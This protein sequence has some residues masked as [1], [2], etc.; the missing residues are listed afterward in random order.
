MK[1]TENP[2]AVKSF[3]FALKIVDLYDIIVKK[4][5]FSLGDQVLRSGTSIGANIREGL[6]GQSK[7]DFISKLNVA[8]KEAGETEYWLDLFFHS[9]IISQDD[10]DNLIKDC[11]ELI[12]ILI[13][14]IKTSR[15]NLNSQS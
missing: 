5:H 13:S 15:S 9:H 4:R 1:V 12:R 6:Y 7:A 14:I 10:Y 2:L 3:A 11:K 8:L